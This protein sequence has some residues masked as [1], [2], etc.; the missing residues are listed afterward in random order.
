MI[1]FLKHSIASASALASSSTR[2]IGGSLAPSDRYPY[3][4]NLE[5]IGCGGSLIAPDVVLTAAHCKDAYYEVHVGKTNLNH[6]WD[7]RDY[8]GIHEY[9]PPKLQ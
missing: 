3:V 9:P 2:I 4:V 5:P 1:V 6:A 7:W 8:S